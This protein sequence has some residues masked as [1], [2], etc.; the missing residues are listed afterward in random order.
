MPLKV[1]GVYDHYP[2]KINVLHMNDVKLIMSLVD[3]HMKQNFI[4]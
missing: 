4:I 1:Q 3:H 2:I